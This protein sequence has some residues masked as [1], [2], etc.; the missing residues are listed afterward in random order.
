M[1][2]WVTT[3]GFACLVTGTQARY[4]AALLAFGAGRSRAGVSLP[5]G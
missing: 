5:S 4:Q 3:R 1:R 2:L